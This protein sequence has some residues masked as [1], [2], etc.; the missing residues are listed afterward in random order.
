VPAHVLA[1]ISNPASKVPIEIKEGDIETVRQKSTDRALAGSAWA[2]QSNYRF[3]IGSGG[4]TSRFA[5]MSSSVSCC[6]D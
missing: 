1:D 2:D 3:A 6:V 5:T 4:E